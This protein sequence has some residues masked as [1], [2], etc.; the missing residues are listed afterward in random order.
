MNTKSIDQHLTGFRDASSETS[1]DVQ[2]LQV[3]DPAIDT[4]RRRIGTLF[5]AIRP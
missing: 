2:D 4:E 5:N 1:I 3:I